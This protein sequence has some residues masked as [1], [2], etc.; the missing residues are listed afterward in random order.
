MPKRTKGP[1]LEETTR[2]QIAEYLPDA[3]DQALESYR[4]FYKKT[5][6]EDAKDFASHHSACKAAI[7]HVELLLKL[8]AWAEL[9]RNDIDADLATLL[10][11]AAGELQR[12]N[13]EEELKI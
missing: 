4:N 10:A 11:D 13:S 7:A 3:V 2:A 5:D 1:T 8:A 9:P 12:Y 6:F